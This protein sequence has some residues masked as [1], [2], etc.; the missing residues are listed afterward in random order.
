[1]YSLQKKKKKPQLYEVI[2]VI[3]DFTIKKQQQGLPW[4]SSG[5]DSKLPMQGAQV[6]FPVRELDP[7]CPS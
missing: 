4:W 3:L 7:T 5:Q 2:I 1:M 6:L